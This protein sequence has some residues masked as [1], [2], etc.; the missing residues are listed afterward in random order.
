M[1]QNWFGGSVGG[2]CGVCWVVFVGE[3]SV[4]EV[5]YVAGKIWQLACGSSWVSGSAMK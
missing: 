5:F 4:R 2:G 1:G 3:L